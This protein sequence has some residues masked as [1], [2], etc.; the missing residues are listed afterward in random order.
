MSAIWSLRPKGNWKYFATTASTKYWSDPAA[1]E[2]PIAAI[3]FSSFQSLR[4]TKNQKA[5]KFARKNSRDQKIK[6][7]GNRWIGVQMTL[8]TS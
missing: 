4:N 1:P 5:Q 6:Q 8:P 2:N 3:V 7:R